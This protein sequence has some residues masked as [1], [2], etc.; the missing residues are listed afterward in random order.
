MT[1]VRLTGA[2]RVWAEFAGVRGT[3]AFLVTRN[4]APVGR[5]YYRSVDDLAEIVDLADLRAE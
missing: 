4:G 3:S 5:G 1:A 2:H